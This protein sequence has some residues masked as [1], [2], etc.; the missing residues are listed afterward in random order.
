M[1]NTQSDVAVRVRHQA[2]QIMMQLPDNKDEASAV[3]AL[4]GKLYD[5]GKGTVDL[6]EIVH[7]VVSN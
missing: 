7:L 4:A 3:L 5:W 6:P 1:P 2:L